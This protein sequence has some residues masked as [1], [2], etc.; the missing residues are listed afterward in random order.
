MGSEMCIRDSMEYAI[1]SHRDFSPE[2]SYDRNDINEEHIIER[3]QMKQLIGKANTA[4]LFDAGRG[5][6][7][8]VSKF[9]ERIAIFQNYSTG[10][11]SS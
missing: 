11:F 5:F 9:T 3:Y 10:V 7:R 1:R 2:D 8:A 6:H 4:F